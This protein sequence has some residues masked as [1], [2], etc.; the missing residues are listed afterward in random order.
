MSQGRAESGPGGRA[1]AAVSGQ[2]VLPHQLQGKEV[3]HP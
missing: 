3:C 1:S 2:T